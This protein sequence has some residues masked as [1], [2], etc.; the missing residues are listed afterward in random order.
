MKTKREKIERKLDGANDLLAAMRYAF[1]QHSPAMQ[2]HSNFYDLAM[3]HFSGVACAGLIVARLQVSGIDPELDYF[4]AYDAA[5]KRACKLKRKLKRAIHDEEQKA[6]CDAIDA[7]AH[8]FS[9]NPEDIKKE[10]DK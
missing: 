10:L 6:L 8:I 2:F 9:R 1:L 3:D 4:K 7:A 5:S